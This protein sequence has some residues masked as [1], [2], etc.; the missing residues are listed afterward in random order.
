MLCWFDLK[1]RVCFT[2]ILAVLVCY[3]GSVWAAEPP[4]FL[5]NRLINPLDHASGMAADSVSLM[6]AVRDQ[7]WNGTCWAFAAIGASEI[8]WRLQ[9]KVAREGNPLL[10]YTLPDLSERYLAWNTYAS[11]TKELNYNYPSYNA[12]WN[13]DLYNAGGWF[14]QATAIMAR[15]TG[16]V[17]EQDC[18]YA[19]KDMPPVE[20]TFN[21]A[22]LLTNAYNDGDN[23]IGYI[24]T[25]EER[26]R[27]KEIIQT[28]GAAAVN[29]NA[30]GFNFSDYEAVHIYYPIQTFPNH[31]VV[32]VGW[33][34]DYDFSQKTDLNYMPSGKGAW[35]VRNSW[36]S[37]PGENG[38]YYLSYE[39]M[40]L[41]SGVGY[42]IETD[43]NRYTR[44]DQHALLG[45]TSWL[46]TESTGKGY[47]ASYQAKASQF[48][49]AVGFYIKED[50]SSYEIQVRAGASSPDAGK[51]VY[52]QQGVFGEDGTPKW[53]GYRTVALDSFVLVPEG[54]DYTVTVKVTGP[55]G[56]VD[57]PVLYSSRDDNLYIDT[58]ATT[59]SP[60][61]NFI[62]MNGDWVDTTTQNST[63]STAMRSLAKD[64]NLANGGDFSVSWLDDGGAGGSIINLG[65]ADELYGSDP[66]NLDRKTLSN[67]TVDLTAGLTDSIYGG[68]I[69]GEG[70]VY[71]VGTGHLTLSGN[72]T[73]T[74]GSV[75]SGGVLQIDGR[76]ASNVYSQ[77]GGIVSGSGTIGASLYNQG[78][79]QAG[80]YGQPGTLTVEGD[81]DSTG[82]IAVVVSNNA[83]GKIA[84][85]GSASINGT[86]LV[87][88][89]GSIY[90]P[91]A[92]YQI[93]TAANITGSFVSLPLTG[94]LS[95]EG[96]HDGVSAQ[97]HFVKQNNMVNLSANQ[98]QTYQQ[99]NAMYNNLT[100][101]PSQRGM[102]SLY[103]LSSETTK[104]ALTEIYGGAQVNQANI[105]QRNKTIGEAISARLTQIKYTENKEFALGLPS[106]AEA[107]FEER[108]VIPLELNAE[109][110]WWMK[111]YKNWGEND[112]QD[113]MPSINNQSFGVILGRDQKVDDNWRT[114]MFFA[115]GKN[116]INASNANSASRDYRLGVYSAYN[117]G[118]GEFYTYLDFGRQY[119]ET[120]RYLQQLGLQ[121]DS[122]YDSDTLSFG[123][124][125]KY[126]LQHE[127]G[128]AWKVSPYAGINI[129][130]YNQ[131]GY[132]EHGAGIF[133]QQADRLINTY[134]TG[135]IGVEIAREIPKGRYAMNI[136]CKRVFSGDNPELRIAYS[137]NPNEKLKI[138]G[139][140][141]DKEYVVLG[142]N[143]QGEI[144]NNWKIT[145]Q[146][147]S[148]IG[149]RS[150]SL[151]ASV[152]IRH[153]W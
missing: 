49:K 60:G 93:L 5:D 153:S 106:I 118:A 139:N 145:G 47:A 76:V 8:N 84:V 68:A 69:I 150:R 10:V 98:L 89:T 27:L 74:G 127:K 19:D 58:S 53:L 123:A 51:M 99:M 16:L 134:S 55:T 62:Y 52:T 136:G 32:L 119:N 135:E 36:G 2:G 48:I 12:Y 35:I 41:T 108:T 34:D 151:T 102:D 110:S 20:H 112:A 39:D 37:G 22:G 125:A 103:N 71:K 128:K 107:A 14:V 25:P 7:G 142:I 100:G 75:V 88:V 116:D 90:R 81:L 50:S 149:Q 96:I 31:A 17:T 65:S 133:S 97:L 15:G 6:P 92:A 152:M 130:N 144:A 54:E 129:T 115:Y 138:S 120:N 77:T 122:R 143:A 63:M 46:N 91:D 1:K 59:A 141:Q 86:I 140:E 146:M 64:S 147:E 104:Q 57:V 148:E 61:E 83:N 101:S 85:Q 44:L 9:L 24:D 95:A 70:R 111:L 80:S 28:T 137:G 132:K 30:S 113:D 23:E 38:Y 3:Q 82:I 29:I 18:P 66:L 73:Y 26:L 11:P 94:M 131:E 78:V 72:N 45:Y 114:G 117:K 43:A 40:T 109:H 79:V 67:M 21:A 56:S 4:A 13:S 42:G 33:D 87:P 126:N 121:A 105:T 124:T